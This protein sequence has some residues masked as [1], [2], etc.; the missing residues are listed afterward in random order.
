LV[1]R[2]EGPGF[3]V[4]RFDRLAADAAAAEPADRGLVLM[5][6][7]MDEVVF[8]EQGNEVTL[9]KDVANGR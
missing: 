6:T 1:I 7:L 4:S 5:K 2:D 3:D 8:N 9:I